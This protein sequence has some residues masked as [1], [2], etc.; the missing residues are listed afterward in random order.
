MLFDFDDLGRRFADWE[1][2]LDRRAVIWFACDADLV[3]M[4]LDDS[5][6]GPKPQSGAIAYLL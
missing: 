5:I 6:Y 4:F 3:V 1:N 2:H